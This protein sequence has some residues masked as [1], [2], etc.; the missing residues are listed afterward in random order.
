MPAGKQ[1]QQ[2]GAGPSAPPP[3]QKAQKQAQQQQKS[4]AGQGKG[5]GKGKGKAAVVKKE[6]VVIL[7]AR[8][9]EEVEELDV[10]EL[11]EEE[12]EEEEE[13]QPEDEA[14]PAE[15]DLE[16]QGAGAWPVLWGVPPSGR[17]GTEVQESRPRM[18]SALPAAWQA[19]QLTYGPSTVRPPLRQARW[20]GRPAW[21]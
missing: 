6:P 17:P 8:E 15:D 19:R 12:E 1:Q 18:R 3:Q 10:S 14:N 11:E 7:P 9:V 13:E 16:L 2:K 5:T 4:V 20:R 21:P